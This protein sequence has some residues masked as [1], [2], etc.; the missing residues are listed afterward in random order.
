MTM[1]CTAR[2]PAPGA[3]SAYPVAKL[4]LVCV[5]TVIVAVAATPSSSCGQSGCCVCLDC[6]STPTFCSLACLTPLN[7]AD[8]C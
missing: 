2:V 6:Q 4:L 3:R 5:A 8:F 1:V 7:C